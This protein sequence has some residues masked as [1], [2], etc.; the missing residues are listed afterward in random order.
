MLKYKARL[1]RNFKCMCVTM[2]SLVISLFSRDYIKAEI[3]YVIEVS[4]MF[5]LAYKCS[6]FTHRLVFR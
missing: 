6:V 4:A 5:Q 1:K 2:C 3:D